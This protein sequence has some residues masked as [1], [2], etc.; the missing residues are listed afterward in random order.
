[1]R[2][3]ILAYVAPLMLASPA[4]ATSY[5]C[6]LE[7][8]VS[9]LREGETAK[10]MRIETGSSDWK[11]KVNII[12][13]KS[14]NELSYAEVIWP[15]DPIQIAGKYPYIP[16]SEV[17][18]VITA[19]SGG[20]CTFTESA[21]VTMIQIVDQSESKSKVM[22]LP[23]AI[24]GDATTGREPFVALLEGECAKGAVK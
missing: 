16:T 19:I 6:A 3:R 15:T 24:G 9:F 1:M 17:S 4:S 13:S 2:S 14:K 22:I 11:F 8:P 18:G 12:A 7:N 23:S 5:A 20:P 21:C 10:V